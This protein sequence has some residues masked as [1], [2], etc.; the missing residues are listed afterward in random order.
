M[1]KAMILLCMSV[2]LLFSGNRL[3]A[4]EMAAGKQ[5]VDSTKLVVLW[6][7]GEK[8][9]FTK[10]VQIYLYNAKK[11]GWFDQITLIIW[12]PS[13]RLVAGDKELQKMVG[14]LRDA[15][16]KLEACVWCADQYGVSE[17]LKQLGV[18][19]KGMGVYLTKYL[20]EKNTRVMVF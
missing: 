4:Q 7:T 19:V 2:S 9:V 11:Q 18:D 1:K 12:G 10:M 16:V 8:D 3:S 14:E 15:G 6:T 13:S 20:K 17:K 5:A